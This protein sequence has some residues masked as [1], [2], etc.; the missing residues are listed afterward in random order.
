VSFSQNKTEFKWPNGAKAALCLTYDDG[1]KSHL[2]TVAPL[3]KRYNFKAT[4]Y[5]TM[6]SPSLYEDMDQWKALTKDGHELG[7]HT[8][9]HPCQK[10]EKGMDWVKA[11]HNLDDYTSEQISEEILLANT[12]LKALDGKENRTFAYPCAHFFAGGNSYKPFVSSH[13]LSARGSSGER[14]ELLKLSDIDLYN[15]PSW[16]PNGV[17]SQEL[18]SYIQNIILTETFSTFTFHG[19]G[20]EHLTVSKEALE[21]MLEFLNEN[22]ADI[23]VATVA[24]VTAYLSAYRKSMGD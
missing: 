16:A 2:N 13:F 19:I 4:F 5:P 11:Y 9:Y 18:I 6:A 17:S 1:L 10:S 24:E 22:R 20:A 12:M 14:N 21:A 15:L 7:N 23:W 3:L 8:M